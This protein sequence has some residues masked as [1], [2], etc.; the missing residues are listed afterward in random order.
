MP[1]IP[2]P[3]R[4]H[5]VRF[6]KEESMYPETKKEKGIKYKDTIKTVFEIMLKLLFLEIFFSL[7]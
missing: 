2:K 3:I 1:D 6:I 5:N 4:T 7:K